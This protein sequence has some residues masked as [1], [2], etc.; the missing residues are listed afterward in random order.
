MSASRQRFARFGSGET[1]PNSCGVDTKRWLHQSCSEASA[2][3]PVLRH[4]IM[5]MRTGRPVPVFPGVV[6]EVRCVSELLLCNVRTESTKRPVI[7]QSTPRDGIVAVTEAHESPK[8][9]HRVGHAAGGF[10]DDE[11]IDFTDVLSILS[12]DFRPVD[13]LA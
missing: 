11:V 6:T 5:T 9:H 8:A 12:V 1:I 4:A 7:G 10:V 2:R 3:L 13:I